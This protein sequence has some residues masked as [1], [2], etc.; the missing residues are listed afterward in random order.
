[1]LRL[2]RRVRRFKKSSCYRREKRKEIL[3]KEIINNV[4][5]YKKV[6]KM[7][8]KVSNIY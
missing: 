1:M 3:K 4:E 2:K 6:I 7:R 5:F 8:R